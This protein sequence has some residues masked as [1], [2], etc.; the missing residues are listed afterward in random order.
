MCAPHTSSWA[1]KNEW[2]PW[3]LKS[4]CP[5]T[6]RWGNSHSLTHRC[7]AVTTL[8]L[9]YKSNN[10]S[11]STM[12]H[13]HDIQFHCPH[14]TEPPKHNDDDWNCSSMYI[15]VI[16]RQSW[17]CQAIRWCVSWERRDEFF[18]VNFLKNSSSTHWCATAS[19]RQFDIM[20]TGPWASH[21][22]FKTNRS[23][24]LWSLRIGIGSLSAAMTSTILMYNELS[25]SSYSSDQWQKTSSALRCGEILMH[26]VIGNFAHCQRKKRKWK[27]KY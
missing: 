13:E 3:S 16:P 14:T 27:L 7:C 1:M 25:S 12:I 18:I 10:V 15:G 5:T 17:S 23:D 9:W 22:F 26:F 8:C 20:R 2:S 4:R 11:C 6:L 24:I 19:Q 21:R